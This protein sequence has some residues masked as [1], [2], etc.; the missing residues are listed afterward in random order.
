MV[1]WEGAGGAADELAGLVLLA[2]AAAVAVGLVAVLV[3]SRLR[4]PC[5]A[6]Q[7]SRPCASDTRERHQRRAR[8][9]N[10]NWSSMRSAERGDS[11]TIVALAAAEVKSICP[12]PRGCLQMTKT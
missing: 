11:Q 4:S 7:G 10:A 8:S 2:V 3:G 1:A 12:I 6:L 9:C 5:T